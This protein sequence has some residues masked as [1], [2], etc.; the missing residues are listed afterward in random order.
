MV[1]VARVPDGAVWR[2]LRWRDL[3]VVLDRVRA[4]QRGGLLGAVTWRLQLCRFLLL[5]LLLLLLPPPPLLLMLLLLLLLRLLRLLQP[6]MRLL[7]HRGRSH[8][9]L[10]RLLLLLP[11]EAKPKS[12][13]RSIG[14]GW[15][16]SS[17]WVPG[18]CRLVS[19]ELPRATEAG[20]KQPISRALPKGGHLAILGCC[21]WAK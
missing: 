21:S 20:A 10:L 11:V 5:L 6:L 15:L 17:S 2:C 16:G 18:R 8:L 19:I 14:S 13:R 9:L 4:E 3:S 1:Q 7:M 12:D